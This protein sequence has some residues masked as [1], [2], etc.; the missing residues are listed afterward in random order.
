MVAFNLFYRLDKTWTSKYE[1][2]YMSVQLPS[3]ISKFSDF[4]HNQLT[5]SQASPGFYLSAVKSSEN[6]V[7]KGEIVR[8]K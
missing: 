8:N 5:L 1:I 4:N 6:T 7:G 2:V 3:P